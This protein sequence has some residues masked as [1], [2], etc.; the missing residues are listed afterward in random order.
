[1]VAVKTAKASGFVKDAVL[2]LVNVDTTVQEKN[3][4]LAVVINLYC[5]SIAS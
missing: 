4:K 2:H 3:T 5:T 1:M